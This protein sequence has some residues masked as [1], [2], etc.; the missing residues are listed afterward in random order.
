MSVLTKL[1]LLANKDNLFIL[2]LILPIHIAGKQGD[3]TCTNCFTSTIIYQTRRYLKI[4]K[5]AE[6]VQ[7]GQLTQYNN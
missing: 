7:R 6:P 5:V 2:T 3:A 4:Y 1:S